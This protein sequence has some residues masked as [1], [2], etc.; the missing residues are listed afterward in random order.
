MAMMRFPRH[1]AAVGVG[2]GL[3]MALTYAAATWTTWI[4]AV[5][6]MAIASG[7]GNAAG[8]SFGNGFR[9][10]DPSRIGSASGLLAPSAGSVAV[11]LLV[12]IITTVVGW[13][14]PALA[15]AGLRGR[16]LT[17]EWVVGSGLRTLGA[18]IL[19]GIVA[20][21]ALIPLGILVLIAPPLGILVVLLGIPV[22]AYIGIR[23]AFWQLAIY[24][25][26]GIIAGF[27][28][29]WQM[30]RGGVLRMLG[31]GFVAVCISLA[32]G[33]G[34]F[35]LSIPLAVVAPAIGAA[36]STGFG[37]V[38]G[39]FT[40]FLLAV[41]YESQRWRTMPMAPVPPA[42]PDAGPPPADEFG[43]LS[44]PPPPP[45]GVSPPPGTP[46]PPPAW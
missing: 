25:G 44:P 42:V 6:V 43:P 22:L 17:A 19:A 13:I 11:Q 9:F 15:I 29:S 35:I 5:L 31:W 30:T 14:F 3:S 28:A 38:A 4:W 26:A 46:P 40:S 16:P 18:G 1:P 21:V 24:D 33:L 20:L 45:P 32:V 36:L 39:V 23:L 41:L 12:T 2:D 34:V 10:T 8:G 37:A 27:A 7:A